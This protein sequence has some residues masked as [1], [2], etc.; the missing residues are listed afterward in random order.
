MAAPED[1]P[2]GAVRIAESVGRGTA[3][4]VEA[5]GYGA[6]LVWQSIYWLL[7]GR[8]HGQ[9]VRSQPVFAEMMEIGVRAVPIV[10]LLSATIGVML[11]LQGIYQLKRFGLES[12]VVLGVALGM[13]RE[14]APLITGILVAGRS[15]SAL[16]ARLGTMTISQEVDALRVMGINPV[17]FL[18]VPSLVAMVIML[19]ALVLWA[20]LVSIFFAGL[21]ISAELGMTLTSYVGQTLDV[22]IADD[23]MHGLY[24][25]LIFSV[26]ITTVGIVCGSSVTGGAEGVGRVTTNSVVNGITAIVLTDMLFE[27]AATR[28]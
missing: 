13:T 9:T 16:A 5:V 14:F 7:L 28:S 23:V 25:S 11:A 20:D 3:R 22:L 12:Q 17:R 6:S 19:P 1:S 24:K 26:L 21:Y 4:R 10:S 2:S 18:V 15:G 27:F 8:R